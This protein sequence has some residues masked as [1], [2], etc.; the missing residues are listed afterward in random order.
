[1]ISRSKRPRKYDGGASQFFS[2][3]NLTLSEPN[4]NYTTNPI[5]PI[6]S[7]LIKLFSHNSLI[8][9]DREKKTY[10][11]EDDHFNFCLQLQLSKN[12]TL[13]VRYPAKTSHNLLYQPTPTKKH[14]PRWRNYICLTS[15]S[16]S[17]IFLLQY[18][19]LHC[20]IRINYNII[21]IDTRI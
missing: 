1:M 18:S 6:Q 7:N 3:L 17:I 15:V 21:I 10:K 11:K 20:L 12:L 13:V 2:H 16:P 14:N 19:Y 5:N 8:T 4:T 9:P